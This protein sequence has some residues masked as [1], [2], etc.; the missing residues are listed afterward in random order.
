[1]NITYNK[2]INETKKKVLIKKNN[3]FAYYVHYTWFIELNEF[4]KNFLYFQNVDNI[5]QCD[6]V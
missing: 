3:I 4:L 5:K 6:R 1:M 2:I